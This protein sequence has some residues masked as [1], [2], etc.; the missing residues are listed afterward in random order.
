MPFAAPSW[1]PRPLALERGVTEVVEAGAGP[2]LLLIPPL[3]G[4]KEAYAELLPRLARAFRVVAF[5]VRE[6]FDTRPRLPQAVADVARVADA[7]GFERCAL[8]GHSL[9]GAIAQAFALAHPERVAALVLS[10]SFAFVTTPAR[11]APARWLEQPLVVAAL[12]VLPERAA[13]RLARVLAKHSRWVFDPRCDERVCA[14]M[15]AGVKRL[16]LSRLREQI[17]LALEYDLRR[18]SG[19]IATP[20]LLVAGERDTAFALDQLE[21][22]AGRIPGA[23]RARSPGVGHLHPL[24]NPE[25]LADTLQRWLARRIHA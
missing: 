8:F 5:D 4:F 21:T 3:P 16:R 2:P 14:L 22:L 12:R 15:V 25:W 24:S 10:S 20:T 7:A 23:E 11:G 9:G 1:T 19:A 6:R 18:A 17:A 13:T